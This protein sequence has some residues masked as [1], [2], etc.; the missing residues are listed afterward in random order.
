MMLMGD[1][2]LVGVTSTS[3][4]ILNLLSIYCKV[5]YCLYNV[6]FIQKVQMY[7]IKKVNKIQL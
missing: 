3:F 4:V 2:V 1:V 5:S 7:I 6:Y